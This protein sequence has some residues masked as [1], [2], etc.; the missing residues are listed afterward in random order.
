[1][2]RRKLALVLFG[3]LV[4]LFLQ[5]RASRD[6]DL[7]W[8][9]KL[10]QLVLQQGELIRSDPFTATH[11]GEPVPPIAWLS[12]VF[13]A[14]VHRAGSWRLL[15]QVNALVFAGGL[16]LASLTVRGRDNSSLAGILGLS[17]GVLVA[18]P[19][20][21]IRPHTLAMFWFVLFLL[22]AEAELRA[23]RKLALAGAVLIVWQ[24]MHP[25]VLVGA[26]AIGARAGAG[27][28]RCLRDYRA[29]KPW[30]PSVLALLAA[31]ST[32]A[33][34]LGW[35][36]FESSRLNAEVSRELGIS[37]WMPL[38]NSA[39]WQ[40]GAWI[41]WL[42]LGVSLALLVRVRRV[43]CLEDLAT[44]LVLGVLSLSLYRLSLFLAAAMVPMWTR[45]IRL[46]WIIDRGAT[47]VS[48]VPPWEN[49]RARSTADTAAAPDRPLDHGPA[50]KPG[51]AEFADRGGH[52]GVEPVRR[53]LAG[54]IVAGALCCALIVPRLLHWRL[55]DEQLPLRA[56]ERMHEMGV[57]GVIY[58][59]REWG[60]PLIWEGYPAWKVTIDGRLYL[61]TREEWDRYQ[62][63]ALGRVPVS[64]VERLYRPDAFFL[65]PSY[66]ERFVRLL[67]E[68]N[69]W[70]EAY[71]DDNAVVFVRR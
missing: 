66:H 62:Q 61:F 21:E 23:W 47:A 44:L 32:L 63:I 14:V 53:W 17:L 48:A 9:V 59:Y 27:W 46:A 3:C 57:R 37:E 70:R 11:A 56:A 8:Q 60:G 25:S 15:H 69:D 38:W 20:C 65:R 12:Q 41:V 51:L 22:V 35:G 26:V 52:P 71:A 7:F 58:N 5:L 10:G 54:G 34:P 40:A 33:T 24:N 30:L 13:Y 6:V 36:I 64:E 28:L 1:M 16:L 55:F 19:H 49:T 18:A 43:V 2:E 4:V 68:S 39:A 42:A 67:R 29:A 45:W 31:L 50:D